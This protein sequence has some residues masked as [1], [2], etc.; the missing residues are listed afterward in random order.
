MTYLADII[1]HESKEMRENVA[2]AF[3]DRNGKGVCFLI[4]SWDEAPSAH[5]HNQQSYLIRLLKGAGF[6]KKLLHHCSIV[7]T[8][9]PTASAM[10]PCR[11]M[12]CINIL[13]F[14]S[15]KIEEFIELSIRSNAD[16]E[17]LLQT[18]Q[19]RD[20]LCVILH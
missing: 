15:F 9:H 19:E 11:P 8:S 13:G 20:E 7:I 5:Y 14:N 2:K 6:G 4:D 10:L 12:S 17:K 18:L 16:K 3:I 1:P